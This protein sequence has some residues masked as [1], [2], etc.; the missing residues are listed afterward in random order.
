LPPMPEPLS[1]RARWGTGTR[2]DELRRELER[3]RSDIEEE[4]CRALG[5]DGFLVL[6]DGPLRVREPLTVVGFI[7]R[8]HKAY[9]EPDLKQVAHSLSAGE[10]TPLFRF[11]KIRPRYSW[12]VRLAPVASQHPSS[13]LARCEVSTALGIDR[14]AELANLLTRHLPRFAS[15]AFWDARAPQNLVPIA[16]LERRL[17]NLLG[18]RQLVYRRLRSTLQQPQASFLDSHGEADG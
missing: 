14:A 3:A 12:Y 13:G 17:W 1:Y 4:L 18:D 7:K 5:R 6:A 2:P 11:G 16:A 8:H 10:R 15:K 9:L